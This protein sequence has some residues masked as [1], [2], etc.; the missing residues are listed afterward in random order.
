M[1]FKILEINCETGE[2]IERD[3]TKKEIE[4]KNLDE[5]I[6]NEQQSAKAIQKQ[7]ILEILGITEEQ[8]KLLFS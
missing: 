1:T 2:Q 6:W 7:Q 5:K 8:A 3:P 4:Q